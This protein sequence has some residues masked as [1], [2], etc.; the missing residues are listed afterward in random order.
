MWTSLL[1]A[2]ES[3]ETAVKPSDTRLQVPNYPGKTTAR[4]KPA[5]RDDP[6]APEDQFAQKGSHNDPGGIT[7]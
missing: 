1:Q 3:H 5:V 6:A 2:K 7:G 4:E